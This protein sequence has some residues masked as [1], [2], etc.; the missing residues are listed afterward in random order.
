MTQ[1]SL[2]SAAALTLLATMLTGPE[3]WAQPATGHESVRA[4]INADLVL[5]GVQQA[6][7]APALL[8][9]YEAQL[10]LGVRLSPP[11][12]P[13]RWQAQTAMRWR[14]TD[15]PTAVLAGIAARLRF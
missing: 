6:G 11:G 5:W 10:D 15:E 9:R 1:R 13:S 4:E 3:V 8:W 12:H 2:R 14:T 7:Q